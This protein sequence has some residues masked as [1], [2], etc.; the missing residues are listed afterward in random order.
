MWERAARQL[1]SLLSASVE[2]APPAQGPA[3]TGEG[4]GRSIRPTAVEALARAASATFSPW[5]MSISAT[6]MFAPSSAKVSTMERPMLEP[7][8]V[9]MWRGVKPQVQSAASA[10]AAQA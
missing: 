2:N 3:L 6:V 7:P 5:S 4:E 9:T 8:P 10:V 1:L